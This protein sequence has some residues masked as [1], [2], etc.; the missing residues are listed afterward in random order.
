MSMQAT[1]PV[2]TEPAWPVFRAKLLDRREVADGTMA[3]EFEKP[4]AWAFEA[5]QFVDLTLLN[6]TETDSEGDTRHFSVASA[7]FEDTLMIA[8]RMRNAAFKRV[9]KR[10]PVG[11]EVKIEGPFGDLR[12]HNN[13][14][15]PAAVVSGGIGIT[16]FRSIL[17]QPVHQ[18]QKH[19]ISF[20]Y[21]NRR[22][23][24]AIFLEDM[25]AL[26]R[27]S[28]TFTFV[29]TMTEMDKSRLAWDGERGRIDQQMLAKYLAGIKSAIYY[30]SG[31]PGMVNDLR[32][33]LEANGVDRDDIRTEEFTGY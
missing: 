10:L 27:E 8:T 2:S 4:A 24:D 12:L 23:E 28:E 6:P 33:L 26:T 32:T 20:F 22:P 7:P 11:S 16:P 17:K 19:R 5:G 15:R 29:P 13:A 1:D 25:C 14:A 31:P 30:V 18:N 9:L 21:T 3:F